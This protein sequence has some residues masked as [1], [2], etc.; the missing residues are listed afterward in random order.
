MNPPTPHD[1]HLPRARLRAR[2]SRR[3]EPPFNPR[4][5]LLYEI[6]FGAETPSGKAFDV[7]LLLA[8]A[9]SIA[10]VLAESVERVA[11]V[12]GGALSALEWGLTL[13]FT[14]EYVARLLSVRRPHHYALSFF[15]VVDLLAI[16]PSY[17]SLIVGGAQ[18]LLVLRVLRLLRVFRVFKLTRYLGEAH[19]L[20]SA[21][22]ASRHKITVFVFAVMTIVFVMG[23]LM[24]LVEGPEHGFTSI[25][26]AIYWAIVTLT[27]VGYG[28]IAPRTV[29]GQAIASLVMVLGYGIIAVPTGI[30]TVELGRASAAGALRVACPG[31]AA[32][33]HAGDARFCRRCGAPLASDGG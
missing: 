20:M 33:E 8:I 32:E 29:L 12:Y 9:L 28:D 23:A 27:T 24:Y 16:L 14:A 30:V 1:P 5:R 31:C 21:L 26:R 11:Q 10:V 19:T 4:R 6:I 13:L 18:S 17:L 15:G 7:I 22:R 3:E 25:P 2:P